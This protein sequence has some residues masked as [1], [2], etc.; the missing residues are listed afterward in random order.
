MRPTQA[1]RR[2]FGSQFSPSLESQLQRADS[3]DQGA[4]GCETSRNITLT[5]AS[6]C[7]TGFQILLPKLK[8]KTS[9]RTSTQKLRVSIFTSF[10]AD[11]SD[12]RIAL[13]FVVGCYLKELERR[14]LHH[15]GNDAPC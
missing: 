15:G 3:V 11:T 13:E 9:S 7:H 6:S 5:T 8:D 2:D 4:D 12:L 10:S 14:H 1:Q